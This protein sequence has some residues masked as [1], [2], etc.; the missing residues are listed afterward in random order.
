M[1]SIA[2]LRRPELALHWHEAV[3][4]VAEV[5]A[6]LRARGRVRVPALDAI[7]LD[8]DGTLRLLDEDRKQMPASGTPGQQLGEMLEVLMSSV[9]CPPELR[10]LIDDTKTDPPGHST[11]EA[12]ADALAFFER[13]GRQDLLKS[14][15]ERASAVALEAQTNTEL[16]RLETRTRSLPDNAGARVP[17]LSSRTRRLVLAGAAAVV[18][19]GA[20]AGGLLAL[21]ADTP[22]Q[23]T[24]KERMQAS[25][26]RVDQ[27]AKNAIAAI[28]PPKQQAPAAPAL[29]S[30]APPAVAPRA[31]RKAVR[32]GSHERPIAVS[33][34]ELQAWS[35]ASGTA[36]PPATDPP[37]APEP[38]DNTPDVTIYSDARTDVEPP[39]LLRPKLPTQPPATVDPEDIGILEIVVSAT[40]V[41]EQVRLISNANRF[42][43]RMLVAAAKAWPFEP[44]TKDGRPV[45]YR[46]R[47]RVTL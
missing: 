11:I 42:E 39:V 24:I 23:A 31:A 1:V 15:A 18:V 4:I 12:F 34:K 47:I 25:V 17:M 22:A 28:A 21:L 26:E 41:V 27:L 33:F 32:D 8:A 16:Q 13:P 14:L 38:A 20:L 7:I 29:E 6:M 2:N 46:T 10:R 30:T 36:L 9:A 37:E 3:A 5:A 43:E 44:A 40:G 45:R 19:L 35:I